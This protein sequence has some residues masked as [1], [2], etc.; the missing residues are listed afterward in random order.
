M[1]SISSNPYPR[2]GLIPIWT[3]A[4]WYLQ[5]Y[6]S[7]IHRSQLPLGLFVTTAKRNRVRWFKVICYSSPLLWFWWKKQNWLKLEKKNPVD[8]KK[9]GYPFYCKLVFFF[10]WGQKVKVFVYDHNNLVVGVVF[11]LVMFARSLG[12]SPPTLSFWVWIKLS[13]DLSI[14]S[15]CQTT[16]ML[17]RGR[18][19]WE[20]C[21]I[22]Q[23][24][25][26][27]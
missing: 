24:S 11:P 3:T 4:S 5:I 15:P 2:F 1:S 27:D 7:Q 19:R 18:T 25:D 26:F 17:V 10:F 6:F 13:K 16:G 21:D 14:G 20:I 8:K 23:S 12:L 22:W 9:V